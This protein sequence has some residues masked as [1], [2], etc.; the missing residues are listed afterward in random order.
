MCTVAPTGILASGSALP[1]TVGDAPGP[2]VTVCPGRSPS[3]ARMYDGLLPSACTS[4]MRAERFGSYSMRST[5][6]GLLPCSVRAKSI[7]R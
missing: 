1:T 4:A 5:S 6:A 3:G 7:I 2:A